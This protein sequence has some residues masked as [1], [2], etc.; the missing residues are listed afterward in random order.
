MRT[1]AIVLVTLSCLVCGALPAAWA[2]EEQKQPRDA[3]EE[4]RNRKPDPKKVQQML[5]KLKSPKA[6]DRLN[7]AESDTR[8]FE[9]LPLEQKKE[10]IS[11]LIETLKDKDARV[12]VAAARG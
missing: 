3:R 1:V 9:K 4:E 5:A 11:A 6:I 7:A 8:G 2:A 10:V 12:R